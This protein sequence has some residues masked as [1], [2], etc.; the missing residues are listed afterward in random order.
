MT[1]AIQIGGI[2]A[3]LLTP[4]AARAQ[5]P[6]PG[7]AG[8]QLYVAGI[9]G[10]EAVHNTGALAGG[11]IG[12]AMNDRIEV[13]GEG[14]WMQDVVTQQRLS[15]ADTVAAYLQTTQGKPATGTVEA[16]A[17]YVGG[18]LRVML[19]T[20]GSVRPYIAAGAGAAHVTYKPTF[21]L[22]GAD[23]TGSLPSYGVTLGSDITGETTNAAFS[24]TPGVRWG[25][26]AWHLDGQVGLISIRTPDE[27]T[28]VLR[29]S[30]AFGLTF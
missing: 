1:R 10:T 13:F 16:P 22:A 7:Q 8:P 20:K 26:N 24:I 14:L 12:V 18:G 9:G 25:R 5:T 6:A 3:A 23:V 4:L 21:T 30:A 17:G 19:T 2:V 15:H 11:E 28:N 29:V 27:T